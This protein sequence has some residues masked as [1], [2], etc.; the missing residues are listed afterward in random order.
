MKFSEALRKFDENSID[1]LHIDGFHSYEAVSGDFNTWYPK[2]STKAV[3]LFHDTHEFQ[4]KF[5]VHR[6]WAEI[7]NKYPEQCFEFE[8]S[9]GLGVCFP[10]SLNA[11]INF[12]NKL[13]ANFKNIFYLFSVVGDDLYYKLHGKYSLQKNYELDMKDLIDCLKHI[14]NNNP[15]LAKDL[16]Q[17]L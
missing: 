7:K 13:G 10:K 5:G 8:H 4:P 9:H 14:K 3:V 12:Q 16:K 2:L 11:A 1:L 15:D 17:F 6:F